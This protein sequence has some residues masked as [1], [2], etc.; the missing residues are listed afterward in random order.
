MR[1]S[2]APSLEHQIVATL[3]VEQ[4]SPKNNGFPVKAHVTGAESERPKSKNQN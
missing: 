3:M 4:I 2:F 1:V